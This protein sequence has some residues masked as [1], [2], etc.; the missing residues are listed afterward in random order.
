M[1]I[2]KYGGRRT[3][4][5][6][7][8]S[9]L[10]HSEHRIQQRANAVKL[11]RL[12]VTALIAAASTAIVAGVANG[13]PAE[14]THGTDSG[15]DYV[16]S[17]PAAGESSIRVAVT[18]GHFAMNGDSLD[19][20]NNSGQLI[21]QVPLTFRMADRV[22]SFTAQLT[23]SD[24]AVTIA[25]AGSTE[26]AADIAQEPLTSEQR[27]YCWNATLGTTVGVIIGILIGAPFLVLPGM[28]AG[29]II[30]GL[31]G[32]GIAMSAPMPGMPSDA[33]LI[34]KYFRCQQG[35]SPFGG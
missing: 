30:G 2:H 22:V 34:S 33:D 20:S 32:M 6:N 9:A 17:S 16:V 11:N 26:T 35:M 25:S 1:A 28:L 8:G 23:D 27:M 29:I 15:V 19:I 18:G 10:V 12:A 21:G 5:R 4:S 24:Q 13:A 14:P 7:G 31:V 3:G